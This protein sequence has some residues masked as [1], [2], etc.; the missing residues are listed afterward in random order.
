[1]LINQT[2]FLSNIVDI[3][4][5]VSTLADSVKFYSGVTLLFVFH[6]GKRSTLVVTIFVVISGIFRVPP[7]RRGWGCAVVRLQRF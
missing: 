3:E 6:C 4:W 2:D 7:V 1:M 5:E